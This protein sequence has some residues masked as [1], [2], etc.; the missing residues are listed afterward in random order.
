MP[1][2]EDLNR[3]FFDHRVLEIW[4]ADDE[5]IDDPDLLEEESAQIL[6]E[7]ELIKATPKPTVVRFK[8]FGVSLVWPLESSH[9]AIHTW[10]EAELKYAHFDVMSCG[11]RLD[12]LKDTV[13]N[14]FNPRYVV[15]D[16]QDMDHPER[17]KLFLAKTRLE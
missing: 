12:R 7:L 5:I 17:P 8:P 9:L 15:E 16:Y 1:R 6:D 11:P 14:H 4:G 10:P 13:Q 3:P 2:T